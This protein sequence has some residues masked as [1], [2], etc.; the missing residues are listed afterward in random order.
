MALA[1]PSA[2]IALAGILFA[3]YRAAISLEGMQAVA[4]VLWYL[5]FL[6]GTLGI[7]NLVPAFPL[8]GG[9]M[10]RAALWGW[11]GDITWATRIA[12]NAGN[13]FGILLIILGVMEILRGDFIAGMW[14]FLIGTFLRGAAGAS[15]QQTLAQRMLAGIS[16]AQ[17][18]TANPIVVPPTLSIS[19][20][21]ED[22]VY[23]Y[24]HREFPV[25][26]GG[27]VVGIIGTKQAASLDRSR[28]PD[29]PVVEV[30][31]PCTAFDTIAP[32]VPVLAALAQMRRAGRNHLFVL[33][34]GHIIGVISL[35]DLVDLLSVKL[36]V[37][38]VGETWVGAGTGQGPSDRT[39][40]AREIG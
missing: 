18:M 5:G 30:Q 25:A 34:N 21:I 2:S 29:T 24:H 11:R 23:R 39:S 7:F 1:G 32:D 31:A 6:N 12:A 16:V 38:G 9:R 40:R 22:Y 35:R 27:V 37:A 15:Y 20:F 28:W 4:E 8:D 3:L 19:D 33:Q 26:R 10:L 36:E 17:V 13:A 14:Q